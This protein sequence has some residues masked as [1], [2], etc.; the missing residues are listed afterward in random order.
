MLVVISSEA[1][2]KR[3]IYH[4]MGCIY[5]ERIKFQNRLEIK[6][7]QAEKEGYCECKYCAGLRGDVRTHKA[8]I[9]SWTHKKEMEFK[10]DDH[11]ET[12]YIKTFFDKIRYVNV[13]PEGNKM[14]EVH[15]LYHRNKFE[16]NTDYQELIRG[17]FHRQKDVKQT[18][19]LVKLVEYIDAHDKAKVVIQDDYHNLPRR[20]KKQ[21]KYYKQAER[22]VKREAVK[23]MDTLFAMLER[24]NPSL[25]NVSIYE[26]SSVC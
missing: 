7:E 14:N 10:F 15:F 5:A 8:Q 13:Y 19:S 3:K 9:L 6:V 23:R 16:A 1:P 25:K 21:K 24:Q 17:E 18:D 12:L 4:K 20:T 2:K 11:T 22:K 26:R